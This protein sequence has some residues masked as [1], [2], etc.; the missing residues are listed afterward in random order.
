LGAGG[1]WFE[2]SRPDHFFQNTSEHLRRA[3]YWWRAPWDTVG[4]SC[5]LHRRVANRPSNY[6]LR[7]PTATTSANTARGTGR[8]DETTRQNVCRRWR[9]DDRADDGHL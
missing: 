9:N 8:R 1:R 5:N 6:L 4:T 3:R 2:S 7:W